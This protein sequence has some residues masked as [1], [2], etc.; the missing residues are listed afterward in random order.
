MAVYLSHSDPQLTIVAISAHE[1]QF[2]QR[3]LPS[4]LRNFE[5]PREKLGTYMVRLKVLAAFQALILAGVL[6]VVL[7][8]PDE[9]ARTWFPEAYNLNPADSVVRVFMPFIFGSLLGAFIALP[10]K[11]H[12]TRTNELPRSLERLDGASRLF[13]GYL[14]AA[15]GSATIAAIFSALEQEG[16]MTILWFGVAAGVFGSAFHLRR[17]FAA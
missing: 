4:V 8:G 10:W 2:E 15:L 11:G 9:F 12:I 6:Y 5:L 3:N 14:S 16:L 17:M 1:R 7:V 13:H